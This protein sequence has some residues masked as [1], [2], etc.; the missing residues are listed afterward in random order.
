MRSRYWCRGNLMDTP[1]EPGVASSAM[2]SPRV[3]GQMSR[4]PGGNVLRRELS[5]LTQYSA[6]IDPRLGLSAVGLENVDQSNPR[7]PNGGDESE[8]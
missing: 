2:I 8:L 3:A 4:R 1:L 7:G 6:L 5:Q